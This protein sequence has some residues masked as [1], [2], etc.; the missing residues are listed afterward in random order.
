MIYKDTGH[1]EVVEITYDSSLVTYQDLLKVFWKNID[2]FDAAGQFCDKGESYRSVTFYKNKMQKNYIEKT[3]KDIESK[4]EDKQVVT[5]IWKFKKF[6]P[7]EDYHQDYY[8]NNFLR[9]LAYKSGCQRE[10]R[11]NKIWN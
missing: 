10:E 7:A 1:V 11:L 3:I 9:Y 6:Y 4:F 8:Q 2:P 5:L